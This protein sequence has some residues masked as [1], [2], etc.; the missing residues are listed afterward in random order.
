MGHAADAR[1]PARR[2]LACMTEPTRWSLLQLALW[3]CVVA[4]SIWFGGMLFQMRVVVPMWNED[5]PSSVR[6]FF[7]RTRYAE[8]VGRFFGARF[9]AARAL[10][11]ALAF[12]LAWNFPEHQ[13]ALA[14][15]LGCVVATIIHAVFYMYR[16]NR[17]LMDRAGEHL[18]PDQVRTLAQTWVAHDQMRFAIG[19]VT[20]AALLWAFQLPNPSVDGPRW[21]PPRADAAETTARQGQSTD[22]VHPGEA[23]LFIGGNDLERLQ[24][25]GAICGF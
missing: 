9:M 10:L 19:G 3:C 16:I 17:Q 18:T 13:F 6:R 20:L 15:A 11:V 22:C 14:I 23:L 7:G 21:G 25:E 24:A 2:Y 8:T 5:P 4:W 12:C 1:A